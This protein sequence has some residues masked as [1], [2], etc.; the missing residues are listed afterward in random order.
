MDAAA[1]FF[2]LVWCWF[3]LRAVKSW[4]LQ[5]IP[6]RSR[7]QNSHGFQWSQD[8]HPWFSA[9]SFVLA[10]QMKYFFFFR[11]WAVTLHV[12]TMLTWV[13]TLSAAM[14]HLAG[15][16][17]TPREVQVKYFLPTPFWIRFSAGSAWQDT[18]PHFLLSID[19][20]TLLEL[21]KRMSAEMLWWLI[22]QFVLQINHRTSQS[23]WAICKEWSCHW[24]MKVLLTKGARLIALENKIIY[25][26][27]QEWSAAEQAS[28]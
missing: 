20:C 4:P 26:M 5:A 18:W 23:L 8:F 13:C 7:W 19:I 1:A 12:I 14:Q 16:H 6:S 15:K 3:F 28:P 11:L 27:V 24:K 21:R 17:C 9:A 10:L 22:M 25:S 2:L